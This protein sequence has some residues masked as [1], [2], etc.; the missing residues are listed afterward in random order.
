MMA[1][2]LYHMFKDLKDF[3]PSDYEE[4]MNPIPPKPRKQDIQDALE[5]LQS[6][7]EYKITP[8]LVAS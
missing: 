4:L 1:V 5:L 6:V 3:H 7:G 2:C 8:I